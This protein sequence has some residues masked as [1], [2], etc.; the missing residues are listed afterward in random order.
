M[1]YGPSGF[2]RLGSIVPENDPKARMFEV[3]QPITTS[4][5]LLIYLGSG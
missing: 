5:A 2:V 1:E 4:F 3:I